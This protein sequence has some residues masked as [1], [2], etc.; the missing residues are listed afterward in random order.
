M[1]RVTIIGLAGGIGSGKSTVAAMFARLGAVVVDAD[2]MCHHLLLEDET[3]AKV[4]KRFGP[5]VFS[6]NGEIDRKALGAVVFEDRKNLGALTKML[7]PPVMKEVHRVVRHARKN[8]RTP[9]VMLDVALLLEAD[10]AKVCN[11]L[12]FVEADRRVRERRVRQDRNWDAWEME[13]REKFQKSINKKIQMAD[14]V[15][16]NSLSKRETF[17]QVRHI[18]R[19]IFH[20]RN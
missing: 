10:M 3:K 5:E 20:E 13:K 1:S 4:R 12:I 16:N 19:K 7:H 18:W 8:E 9:A 14:Y 2:E 6:R 15:I 11:L 17:D